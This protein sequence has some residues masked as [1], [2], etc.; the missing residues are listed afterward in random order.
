MITALVLDDESPARRRLGELLAEH[1]DVTVVGEADDVRTAIRRIAEHAPDVV[2][3]D[4]SLP[5]G[6]GF[7][8][9]DLLGLEKRP[10][11]VIVTAHS[12]HAVQA[13]EIG[14]VDYVLKPFARARLAVALSRVRDHLA[15]GALVGPSGP[16]AVSRIPVMSAGKVRFVDVDRIESI[17]AERNYVRIHAGTRPMLVRTTLRQIEQRL[18]PQTFVRVNRSV[19]V[20]ADRITEIEVLPHGE[21]ALRLAGGDQVISGRAHSAAIR[22]ALGIT[23][24]GRS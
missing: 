24:P 11:I 20:R 23:G 17:R 16:P 6:N 8:L 14:A 7:E 9:V 13:F 4:I 22:T 5:G 18:P 15:R 19:L 1:P 2:F 12:D 10:A 3:L 21:L